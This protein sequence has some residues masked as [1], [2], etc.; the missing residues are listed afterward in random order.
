M[1]SAVKHVK[2]IYVYLCLSILETL[3]RE[4]LYKQNNLSTTNYFS[5]Y[6]KWEMNDQV[7]LVK[8]IWMY[9]NVYS[10]VYMYYDVTCIYVY[11]YVIQRN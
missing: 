11:M 10:G 4:H 7:W 3:N 5:E 2:G 1:S 9:M 8:L 6:C